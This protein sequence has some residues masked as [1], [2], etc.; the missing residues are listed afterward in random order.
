MLRPMNQFPIVKSI[1]APYRS[2]VDFTVVS[3][4]VIESCP[5]HHFP[6]QV[7]MGDN[8]NLCHIMSVIITC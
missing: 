2:T 8:K 7:G 6:P 3:K 1:S 4:G 5:M